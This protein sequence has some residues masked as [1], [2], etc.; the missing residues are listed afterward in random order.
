[1]AARNLSQIMEEF[2][3]NIKIHYKVQTP[4]RRWKQAGAPLNQRKRS[5]GS[6]VRQKSVRSF[7]SR[8]QN[9]YR[10]KKEGRRMTSIG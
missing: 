6:G 2:P 1:M 7:I 9:F 5:Q 3:S 8:T 10:L 4:S